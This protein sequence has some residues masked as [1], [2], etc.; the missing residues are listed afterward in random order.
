MRE[1]THLKSC[2]ISERNVLVSW[3]VADMKDKILHGE[4]RIFLIDL[5]LMGY[6]HE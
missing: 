1:L 3:K 4:Y 5:N 6:L 2:F